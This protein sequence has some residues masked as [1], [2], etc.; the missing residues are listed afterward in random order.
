M[1]ESAPAPMPVQ[2]R[3]Y[4]L[5]VLRGIALFGVLTIN[6]QV[7]AGPIVAR[8]A[9][10]IVQA[11]I[12]IF[13]QSKFISLFSFL[14]G[15]GFAIQMSR[16][17]AKGTRLLSFYPRRLLALALFGLI[18]GFLIWPGDILLTYAILGALLLLFRNQSQRALLYW[19]GSIVASLLLVLTGL[20]IA[21]TLG[22]R[23]PDEGNAVPDPSAVQQAVAYAPRSVLQFV[24][25]NWHARIGSLDDLII[26][27]PLL[28]LFLLGL[29]VWRTGVVEHLDERKPVLKRVCAVFLP[30]GLALNTANTLLPVLRPFTAFT[31]WFVNVL[32]L[33]FPPILSVGYAA[34]LAVLIQNSV[35]KQRFM[36]LAAVGRMALTNYLMQSVVCTTIFFFAGLY[37]KLGPASD[38]ALTAGVY[39]GQVLLSGWWLARYRYGP[40]EWLWRGM[41]YGS[42]PAMLR[43]DG[44]ETHRRTAGNDI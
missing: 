1:A 40:M 13:I 14:F 28:S 32:G 43:V 21:T 5:D 33:I 38:L 20:Y 30:L 11:F 35:W 15:L 39:G 23:A 8:R 42:F 27:I 2:E 3:I 25:D 10:V 7:F 41:T 34:A 37:G 24:G 18:H 17:A 19:A 29:W 16:A 36:P 9:D 12:D 26:S 6:M 44:R 4:Y 31:D 22:L